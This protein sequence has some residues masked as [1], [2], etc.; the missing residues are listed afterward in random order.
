MTMVK[1]YEPI[2]AYNIHED[3]RYVLYKD[4]ELIQVENAKL[5]TD[6]K[7]ISECKELCA[8]CKKRVEQALK[9]D[10]DDNGA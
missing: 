2:T 5:K 9:G 7:I 8:N 6:I 3:G 1:R 4:Y 10:T